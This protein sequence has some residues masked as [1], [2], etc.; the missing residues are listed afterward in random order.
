MFYRLLASVLCLVMSTMPCWSE[1][2]QA[3]QP[4]G[5]ISALIPSAERNSKPT[6]AKDEVDW[7]DLLK[8]E[9]TGR[10][11]AALSDGS[12]LSMG[13][14]TEMRVLQHDAKSQQTSIQ[15]GIGAMRSRVVKLTNPGAKFE[16]HTPQAVI[17]VIGT[18]FFVLVTPRF[19]RVICYVGSLSVTPVPGAQAAAAQQGAAAQGAVTVAAGSMVQ[20]EDNVAPTVTP[21][22]RSLQD[23][24]MA[25][26]D[27]EPPH[28]GSSAPAHTLR[29][30]IIGIAISGALAGAVIGTTR[31]GTGNGG[32]SQPGSA[33]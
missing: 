9:H 22:P 6:R 15:L 19:T 25:L 28:V 2:P 18:D 14:D 1:P 8:T 30:V 4:A 26:T 7:N 32:R 5:Q 11:R 21:T 16:V 3:T 24:S 13:S 33:P 10:L 20:V 29:N 12:T 31:T 17:G 23:E 27:V